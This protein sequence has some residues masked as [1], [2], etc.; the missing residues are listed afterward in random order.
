[1][2]DVR[3]RRTPAWRPFWTINSPK[4]GAV[5]ASSGFIHLLTSIR[6]FLAV[7]ISSKAKAL[8]SV[9][10]K[11]LIAV[12]EQAKGE[13]GR[14]WERWENKNSPDIRGHLSGIEYL[15]PLPLYSGGEG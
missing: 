9:V 7:A 1:M 14:G 5:E 6:S 15:S 4:T 3:G 11:K 8:S 12:R 10:R 2:G 13:A